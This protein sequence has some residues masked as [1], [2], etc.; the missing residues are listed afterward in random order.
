MAGVNFAQ[1]LVDIVNNG[2]C[3][4]VLPIDVPIHANHAHGVASNRRI[5]TSHAMDRDGALSVVT[6]EECRLPM[7]VHD[8]PQQPRN[9]SGV[10]GANATKRNEAVGWQ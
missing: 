5:E 10:A 9:I 4:E 2:V 3:F 8:A 6:D 7:L 1:P